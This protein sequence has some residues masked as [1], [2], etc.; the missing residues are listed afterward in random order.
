MPDGQP[1]S[2][3]VWVDYDDSHVL[4]NTALERQKCRNMRDDPD[5]ALLVV[6]PENAA[7]WIEVRGH[8][9][10]ITP[11]GAVEH[12]DRLAKRYTGKERFHGDAY[13]VEQ[14]QEE[15]RVIVR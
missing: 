8:V 5:M 7:R 10:E 9:A 2:S 14:Q 1:Q 11:C 3:I 12:A 4:I 6:D 15:T 13:P